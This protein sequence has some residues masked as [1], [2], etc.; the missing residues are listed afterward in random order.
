MSPRNVS[1]LNYPTKD[2]LKERK[3]RSKSHNRQNT[4]TPTTPTRANRTPLTPGHPK[5]NEQLKNKKKLIKTN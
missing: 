1:L 5:R 3:I 2:F 4:T